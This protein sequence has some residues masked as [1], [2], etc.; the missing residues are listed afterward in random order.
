MVSELTTGKECSVSKSTDQ[1]C[2]LLVPVSES[3]GIPLSDI[4]FIL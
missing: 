4:T 1:K 2:E 3:S